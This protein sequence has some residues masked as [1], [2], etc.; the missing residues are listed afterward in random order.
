MKQAGIT[1]QLRAGFMILENPIFYGL[2]IAPA[3]ALLTKLLDKAVHHTGDYG[4]HQSRVYDIGESDLILLRLR[5]NSQLNGKPV[6]H[7]ARRIRDN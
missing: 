2:D 7:T 6:H 5:L 1:K 3:P 4:N